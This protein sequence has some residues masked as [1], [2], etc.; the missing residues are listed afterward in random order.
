MSGYPY[1]I[2]IIGLDLDGTVFNDDKEI[3]PRTLAAIREAAARGIVVLPAT[4]RPASGVPREFLEVP[5]V[6]YA[7][8]SNGAT[9][10]RLSDGSRLVFLPFQARTALGLHDLLAPMDCICNVFIG[11]KSYTPRQSAHQLDIFSPKNILRYIKDTRIQ[12]EDLRQAILDHPNEVEKLTVLFRNHQEREK[13]WAAV[14]QAF[15]EVEIT[16]SFDNNMELNAPGVHKG[17]ALLTLAKQL[18]YGPENV[19]ACGDSSNDLAML[20]SVGLSVAMGNADE[21]VKAVAK[22]ITDDN[23]HDG[24]AKAIE[25][26]AL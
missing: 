11:G 6:E 12:V 21:T 10:T 14:A 15:P 9:I 24:V 8:T 1:P 23:N 2:K 22:V 18:G 3:T 20:R 5:G 19:M 13:A 4:G 7:L 16:S 17:I 26:Y 25:T